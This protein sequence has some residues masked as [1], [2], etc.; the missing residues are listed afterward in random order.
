MKYPKEGKTRKEVF[1]TMAQGRD[2]SAGVR[3]CQGGVPCGS[4]VGRMEDDFY[5]QWCILGQINI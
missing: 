2:M 3:W 1:P 5:K 4:R